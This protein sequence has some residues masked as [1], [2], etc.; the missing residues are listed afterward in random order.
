M[1]NT[2]DPSL[3][4][5][6]TDILDAE[7]WLNLILRHRSE[8]EQHSLRESY[9][10]VVNMY[11]DQKR[12][13]GEFYISHV[14]NI[15]DILNDLGMETDVLIAAILHDVLKLEYMTREEIK[16]RFGRT[17]ECLVGGVTEMLI[18][19][20]EYEKRDLKKE[21]RY[22]TEKLRNV[23]LM[24]V[25]DV[26]IILI[27]LAN[28]LH[29]IRTLRYLPDET[30][31]VY[32]AQET[33][34][35]FVPLASRLGIWQI[36]WELEDLSFRHLHPQEYK[37]LAKL[38]DERRLDR[39]EYI[40]KI[41]DL[42][43]TELKNVNISAEVHGRPKHIYSIWNKMRRKQL[44]FEKIF[45]VRAVRILVNEVSDCY[46]VLGIVHNKWKP[47]PG[48]FDDY[49][50]NPKNNNYQSLHTAV[51]GPDQKIFEVQIRTH[52]MH[53]HAEL[54][55]A[56]HWRY[57]ED[58][59][60]DKGF[61]EK[62]AW[63]RQVLKGAEESGDANEF[64]EHFRSE[65]VEDRVYVLSPKG[66]VIDLPNGA[67][68][69]DFAYYIH[70]DLGHRCRGA[71]VNTR[72]VPLTYTLKNGE[73]VE[74][75][76]SKEIKPSRD[77]LMPHLGYIKT[78]RARSKIRQW[79]KK[80]DVEQHLHVGESMLD[81][82]LTRLNV[83]HAIKE[84]IARLLRY[85]TLNDLFIAISKGDI[86]TAKVVYAINEQVLLESEKSKKPI[87]KRRKKH[88]SATPETEQ[89]PEN[90]EVL[91]KGVKGLVTQMA[92]CC[93]PVP[94]DE[95]IG[96]VS[97]GKGI[98]VHKRDCSN[99]IHWE[100]QGSE[101]LIEVEWMEKIKPQTLYPMNVRIRAF[102]RTGLLRDVSAIMSGENINILAAN[103]MTNKMDNTVKMTLTLE[104]NTLSQ[105]SR[106]LAKIDILPNVTEVSRKI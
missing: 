81:K 74:I 35:L 1:V 88:D 2:K 86:T 48:E 36:K 17:V 70:T 34:D 50:A 54:G 96:Y 6:V 7:H 102:D 69:L 53:H 58:A 3:I 9:Q 39:E 40:K 16:S 105:L 55:V 103:T 76:T 106:A 92:K 64:I 45:D 84:E 100:D 72:I 41:L 5:V 80:Q 85:K 19:E 51:V 46:T 57:K 77:W 62:V 90:S 78:S 87:K 101:R 8:Q 67:T 31:Q 38:L 33:M 42:L 10:L 91:I 61:E 37:E 49:I 82:E 60:Y 12:P 29:D 95:I 22:K 66:E 25:K 65:M 26:R 28:R 13:S 98:V 24:M 93:T 23:I 44:C 73:H 99:A 104:V 21:R 71:K 68:P 52:T 20:G 14:L 59:I 97:K 79:L 11:G 94:C 75:L 18:S 43:E 47:V 4:P 63:L 89:S 15:A 32:I 56:S 27:K 30:Q 83:N